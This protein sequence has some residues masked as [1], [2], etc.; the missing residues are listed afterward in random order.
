MKFKCKNSTRSKLLQC[1]SFATSN[2]AHL[3]W[4][5]F[6][7]YKLAPIAITRKLGFAKNMLNLRK[8]MQG[9]HSHSMK[10]APGMH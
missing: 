8:C 6:P 4:L 9:A 1:Y 7:D 5:I 2:V 3:Q 10:N